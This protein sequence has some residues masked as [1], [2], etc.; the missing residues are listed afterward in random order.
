MLG[1]G[2][3]EQQYIPEY[4]Y[5]KLRSV[6][7]D[8]HCTATIGRIG[9]ISHI[10]DSVKRF[11]FDDD[12][13]IS[14]IEATSLVSYVAAAKTGIPVLETMCGDVENTVPLL[15]GSAKAKG[16]NKYINYVAHEWYGG[17]DNED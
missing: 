13:G 17:V 5:Y 14:V 6:T 16:W 11:G 12:I 7:L 9:F 1:F 15:R 8:D 3:M 2:F 10:N 4:K